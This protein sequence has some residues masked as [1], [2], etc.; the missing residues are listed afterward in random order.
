MET[1]LTLWVVSGR[2]DGSGS[3]NPVIVD[4]LVGSNDDAIA[5]PSVYIDIITGQGHMADPVYFNDLPPNPVVSGVGP[6]TTMDTVRRTV[7]ECPWMAK[8]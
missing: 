3:S 6:T 7:S 1:R 4:W 2:A 5:L 8:R